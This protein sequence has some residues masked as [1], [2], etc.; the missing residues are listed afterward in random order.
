M[1]NYDFTGAEIYAKGSSSSRPNVQCPVVSYSLMNVSASLR[2]VS[3]G[4]NLR[5][6]T[7][8]ELSQLSLNL[9]SGCLTETET[10]LVSYCGVNT[11]WE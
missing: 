6:Q 5:L 9:V 2:V 3:Q 11:K 4:L 7:V 1:K 10:G 8:S